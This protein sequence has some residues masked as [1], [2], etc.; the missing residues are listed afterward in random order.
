M[1]ATHTYSPNPHAP[2]T[3]GTQV[4]TTRRYARYAETHPVQPL[5]GLREPRAASVFLLRG[6]FP[7]QNFPKILLRMSLEEMV[8][9]SS[10]KW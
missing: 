3:A 5:K 7:I 9:V 8:P 4:A 1:P 10:P 2:A 6:Y